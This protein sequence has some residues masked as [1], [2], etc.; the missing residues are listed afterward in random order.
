MSTPGDSPLENRAAFIGSDDDLDASL[1]R[2]R[3]IVIR[4]VEQATAPKLEARQRP[5]SIWSR[6]FGARER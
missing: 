3:Y 2:L 1:Q 4:R 5:M 6:L